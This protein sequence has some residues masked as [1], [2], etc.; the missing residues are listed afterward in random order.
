MYCM[1]IV[2]NTPWKALP[3][4]F[5]QTTTCIRSPLATQT[6]PITTLSPPLPHPLVPEL[7]QSE[8]SVVLHSLISDKPLNIV[9]VDQSEVVLLL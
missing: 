8:P 2:G 9:N 3:V 4:T 5:R 1:Y 6:I 7:K